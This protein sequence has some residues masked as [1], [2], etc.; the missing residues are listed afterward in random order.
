MLQFTPPSGCAERVVNQA[1][2]NTD[3]K[4]YAD[5]SL[6]T[7]FKLYPFE[8]WGWRQHILNVIETTKNKKLT[9]TY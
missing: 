8:S 2:T 1:Q 3:T 5:L 9:P 6:S 7:F 4:S